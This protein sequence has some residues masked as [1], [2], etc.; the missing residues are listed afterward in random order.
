MEI[1]I[2][3]TDLMD[4]E[5]IIILQDFEKDSLQKEHKV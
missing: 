5:R 1:E 3:Q 2:L 4:K